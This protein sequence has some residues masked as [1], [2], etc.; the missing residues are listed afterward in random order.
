MLVGPPG[1]CPA[2]TYVKI[3]LC[4]VNLDFV[5]LMV[6]SMHILVEFVEITLPKEPHFILFPHLQPSWIS[7]Q[8]LKHNGDVYSKKHYV[9]DLWQV[10]GFLWVLQFHPPIKLTTSI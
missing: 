1:N 4:V 6:N 7:E 9:G 10:C 8:H 3:A 2:C 5:F